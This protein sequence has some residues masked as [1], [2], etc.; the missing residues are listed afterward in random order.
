MKCVL[1][2]HFRGIFAASPKSPTTASMTPSDNLRI[3]TFWSSEIAM[4][5]CDLKQKS[6][7][8]THFTG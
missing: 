3:S 5:V 7:M 8:M 1:P 2:Y 4:N 6:L